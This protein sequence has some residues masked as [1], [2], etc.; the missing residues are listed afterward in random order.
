MTGPEHPLDLPSIRRSLLGFYDARAR[1][2]PW[3]RTDDP[4]AIWVSEIM[5]QQTRVET[6]IPYW[7]TWM[8]RFPDVDALALADQAE[9]LKAWE[10]LG[11]YSRARNLHRGAQV[12]RERF[13]GRL[14]TTGEELREIPGIGP[15]TGGAIASIA[16]GRAVPA[17]DGNVRRVF[18]RLFDDPAPGPARLESWGAAL[19]DPQRPGDFNQALMEL[20]ATVCTPTSPSCERCP[21]A[22]HCRAYAVGTVSDRPA[23]KKRTKVRDAEFLVRIDP[24]AD[25]RIRVV[26]RGPGLLEGMWC[27][28]EVEV[29]TE[30]VER[31]VDHPGYLGAVDHVFS[32]LRARYHVVLADEP[33][34]ARSIDD[35]LEA[36]V[37]PESGWAEERRVAPAD[38]DDLAL[39]VAQ[40]AIRRLVEG[41]D[42]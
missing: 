9:V 7:E 40:Q 2:L 24:D 33:S 17:V 3:R 8:A 1:D 23:P 10:G 28:P 36:R 29:S 34:A 39:P 14:P 25:G 41:R 19:V 15:Y 20:G 42:A 31:V 26:R 5:C 35:L 22:S 37:P 30:V 21:I 38:L 16:F 18:A 32:H 12:V 4:Y 6:V 11:Y 27:F 13:G